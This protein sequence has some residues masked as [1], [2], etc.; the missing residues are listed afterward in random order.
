M[1]IEKLHNK[2][3]DILGTIYTI[4]IVDELKDD[5]E[6]SYKYGE[7]NH[8]EYIIRIA[9]TAYSI[10]LPNNQMEITF[11]HE[12]MHA[13]CSS[14]CYLS[15]NDDEQFVEWTARCLYKLIKSGLFK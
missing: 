13:I 2:K 11:L 14:G 3:I 7:T 4:K 15:Y 9:K 8:A 12:L 1:D 6:D 5:N 10:K